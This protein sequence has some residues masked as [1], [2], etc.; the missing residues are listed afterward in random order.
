MKITIDTDKKTITI[1]SWW[2]LEVIDIL[3]RYPDFNVISEI[4]PTIN[5][6]KPYIWTS[7]IM[8]NWTKLMPNSRVSQYE[9]SET[10]TEKEYGKPV[11]T[12]ADVKTLNTSF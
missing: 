8:Y 11:F 1:H 7:K 9:L 2:S 3:K 12:T 5:N 10:S 6:P 4:T